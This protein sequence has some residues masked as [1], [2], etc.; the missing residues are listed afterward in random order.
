MTYI[1]YKKYLDL[2]A[3][4]DHIMVKNYLN[5]VTEFSI[6]SEEVKHGL[7]LNPNYLK[8]LR[9][10]NIDFSRIYQIIGLSDLSKLEVFNMRRSFGMTKLPKL[11]KSLK[12]IALTESQI[13]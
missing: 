9:E 13:E 11:P 7:S 8:N 12:S 10:L 2:I 3:Q 5:K 4:R 6:S 1:N